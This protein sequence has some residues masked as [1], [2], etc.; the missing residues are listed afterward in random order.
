[1]VTSKVRQDEELSKIKLDL[2]LD[3]ELEGTFPASDPLK[4]TRRKPL[5]SLA[6]KR[7]SVR[8]KVRDYVKRGE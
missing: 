5:S 2:E 4:I 1:M 6:P 8:R 7:K 3:R